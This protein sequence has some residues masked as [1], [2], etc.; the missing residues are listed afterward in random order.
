MFSF[1]QLISGP[2]GGPNI[3]QTQVRPP[4]AKSQLLPQNLLRIKEFRLLSWRL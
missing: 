2:E 1:L 3:G 4:A